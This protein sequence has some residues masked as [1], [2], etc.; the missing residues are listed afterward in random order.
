MDSSTPQPRRAELDLLLACTDP[1]PER[2]AARL[3]KRPRGDIDWA[4]L[5]GLAIAHG[6][7]PL[8]AHRLLDGAS[9]DLPGE[10]AAG[11]REHLEDNVQRNRVLVDALF[12]ALSA[13]RSRGVAALPFKGQTL[14]ALAYDDFALRR[15]GDLD[16]L[17]R[18]SD[19][20]TA[21]ASLEELGYREATV[22][23]IGRAMTKG[24]HAGYLS[25]Q[26]EYLL[27]RRADQVAIEP[28]W[29]LAPTT[30]AIDLPYESFFRNA[31]PVDL[32]GRR[33][34]TFS[35]PDLLLAVCVHASKHGWTRLQWVLDVAG[36]IERHPRLDAGAVLETARVHGVERMVL[37]GLG[38][39]QRLYGTTLATPAL[40]RVNRD[41]GTAALVKTLTE[42]LLAGP[43]EEPSIWQ[44]STLRM[45]MRER[46]SDKAAYVLRTAT[47]PVERH[48][49]LVALPDPLR[50]L[51]VPL[52]V[53]HDYVAWPLW[54]LGRMGHRGV[55]TLVF[56]RESARR[57][58]ILV[59]DW[60][61]HIREGAG[62]PRMN[63]I[64]RAL[65]GAG[66][67]VTLFPAAPC[68]E[69][70]A[71]LYADIPASVHVVRGRGI[72]DAEEYLRDHAR[73]FSTIIVGR[74]MN[75]ARLA[76]VLDRHPEWFRHARLIYDSEALF[77][78]RTIALH[79]LRGTPLSPDRQTAL[80][81]EE[82]ACSARAD[83]V[84]AVSRG[85]Q[86]LF[87]GHGARN[88]VLVGYPVEPSPTPRSFDARAGILFVGRLADEGSPNVDSLD[89]YRDHVVPMLAKR[90]YPLTVNAAG[91]TNARQRE[92]ETDGAIRYL[93][94]VDDLV[95]LYDQ[96]RVF[97]AP[98]RFAAGTPAKLYE[99]AAHGV[100]IV[101][102][103]LLARQ[104]GWRPGEDLLASA[105]GDAAAFADNVVA[106][107]TQ[108]ELW[109]RLRANALRRVEEECAPRAILA[110]LQRA[111]APRPS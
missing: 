70:K 7:S 45:R 81:A 104:L 55:R 48:Y 6:V 86:A 94:A 35:L 21:C 1:S 33:V 30:L 25:F 16:V 72:D 19:V 77:A 20:S 10:L 53:V 57:N 34:E 92:R 95:P 90:G 8:V 84:L 27:V 101:A 41:R 63:G 17:V 108:P 14:G 107:Y 52:K 82:V 69:A 93:G 24:E 61:P 23:E 58:R 56:A 5:I 110:A 83:V 51:Y 66:Y 2:R 79:E 43:V 13:M 99:A 36:L 9:V 85:E 15:A 32:L 46:W 60:V 71:V 29:A 105:V 40:Q 111:I 103:D 78:M 96:A 100:P 74:P 68:N 102:T 97:I 88:V 65:A 37:V 47:T 18:R 28:H 31:A 106:L 44:L 38:L 26:C 3:G 39:A 59:I 80:I 11:L 54:R 73:E 89:W 42:R 64:L 76:P 22:N 62:F 109:A 75:M 49:R 91:R 4:S 87:A 67:R 50:F 12:E 98:T